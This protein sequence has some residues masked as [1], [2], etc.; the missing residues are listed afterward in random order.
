MSPAM[1][2]AAALDGDS[3]ASSDGGSGEADDKRKHDG[4]GTPE[5]GENAAEGAAVAAEAPCRRA[6]VSVRARSEAPMVR[7]G[8]LNL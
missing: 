4:T 5:R 3:R 7:R 1:R 6:R 2:A 8:W